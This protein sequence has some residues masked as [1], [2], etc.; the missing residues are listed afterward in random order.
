MTTQIHIFHNFLES[1]QADSYAFFWNVEKGGY[2]ISWEKGF[3]FEQGRGPLFAS[4][5]IWR[6][7]VPIGVPATWTT[8]QGNTPPGGGR[9]ETHSMPACS[10]NA[11]DVA[12]CAAV[13]RRVYDTLLADQGQAAGF[14]V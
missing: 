6:H 2:T 4:E 9:R 7:S 1:K 3:F 14:L 10:P 13:Y 8:L 11:G 12:G 5:H